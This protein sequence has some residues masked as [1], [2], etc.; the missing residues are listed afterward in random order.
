ME[1]IKIWQSP[2]SSYP[3]CVKEGSQTPEN[4]NLGHYF[5]T[6]LQMSTFKSAQNI[7][8]KKLEA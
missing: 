4:I 2:A 5:D 3:P 6:A 1:Q 7:F 8:E